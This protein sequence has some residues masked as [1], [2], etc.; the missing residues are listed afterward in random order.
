MFAQAGSQYI[1]EG[2]SRRARV[3]VPI[4]GTG[5]GKLVLTRQEVVKEILR[6]VIAAAAS[7]RFCDHVTVVV[8]LQDYLQQRID[9]AEL[10][11]YLRYLTSYTELKA[12]DE[13]GRGMAVAA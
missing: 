9:L 10:G 6:S 11:D 12:P 3:R 7:D 4:L 13:V 2:H 8:S 5:F 1:I